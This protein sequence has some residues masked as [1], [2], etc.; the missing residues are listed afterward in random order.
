MKKLCL[1]LTLTIILLLALP[2]PVHADEEEAKYNFATAQGNK[3]LG[4]PYGSQG[5]GSIYFYN[6]D[7][8]RITHILLEVSQA[9]EGW[10]VSIEPPTGQTQVS[11]SGMPVTVTENLYVEPGELYQEEP[12]SVPEGMISIKVPGRG[13]T[14]GK[15]ARIKITIPETETPGTTGDITIAAE[16]FWLG[17]SG[18]A[19]VKQ[20]RD[21]DFH[22]TVTSGITGYTEEVIG[23]SENATGQTSESEV[24]HSGEGL[25]TPADQDQ[26][27]GITMN[28]WLL[29][30]IAVIVVVIVLVL[31]IIIIRRRS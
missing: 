15:E 21:F 8:N 9:P 20:A 30:I 4:I 2:L 5:F 28:T 26:S 19:A 16:A 7:G 23:Q 6:I 29:I 1:F 31:L 27:S 24:E 10:S 13:Y 14:L 25:A 3:E 22:V 17:Q 12:A 18:S 11:V